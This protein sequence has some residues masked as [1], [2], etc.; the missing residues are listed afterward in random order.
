MR[1]YTFLLIIP[2]VALLSGC[3]GMN[4][5]FSCNKVGGFKSCTTLDTVSKL[6]SHGYFNK[7]V[8]QNRARS[9]NQILGKSH[10]KGTVTQISEDAGHPVVISEPSTHSLWVNPVT[11][12]IWIAPYVSSDDNAYNFPS[13]VSVV[14]GKGHWRGL[15]QKAIVRGD[16][17]VIDAHQKSHQHKSAKEDKHNTKASS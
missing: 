4:S 9:I 13:T 8:Q 11:A 2:V 15:S 12:R 14:L 16:D 1:A 3:A 6:A 5:K 10:D 17:G 7:K